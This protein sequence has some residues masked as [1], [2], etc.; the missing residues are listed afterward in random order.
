MGLLEGR[1]AQ[2]KTQHQTSLY[3]KCMAPSC[4]GEF[5]T[6]LGLAHLWAWVLSFGVHFISVPFLL[7]LPPS[8][9]SSPLKN[10][11]IPS[12]FLLHHD[13]VPS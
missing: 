1:E 8:L 9:T 11:S 2:L 13:L 12:L 5:L 6:G 4:R 3:E 7:V 10:S